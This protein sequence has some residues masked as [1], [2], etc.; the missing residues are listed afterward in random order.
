MRNEQIEDA[1]MLYG[2]SLN[3]NPS[4]PVVFCNRAQAYKKT[5]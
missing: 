1:I 3:Y 5:K 2:E 4:N